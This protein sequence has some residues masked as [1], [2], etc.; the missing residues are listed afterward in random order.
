MSSGGE[1]YVDASEG[2]DP[3]GAYE[4]SLDLSTRST[5]EIASIAEAAGSTPDTVAWILMAQDA[6]IEEILR[7]DG[8]VSVPSLVLR[9]DPD[10]PLAEYLDANDV[11]RGDDQSDEA[12]EEFRT[13]S[14]GRIVY[15]RTSICEDMARP[16]GV[17]DDELARV[18]HEFWRFIGD[19]PGGR[20]VWDPMIGRLMSEA[21]LEELLQ[22]EPDRL[23][24]LIPEPNVMARQLDLQS[25]GRA[26]LVVGS[27]NGDLVVVEL[28]VG[29]GRPEDLDQLE[30]YLA[31]AYE[32]FTDAGGMLRGLLLCDGTTAAVRERVAQSPHLDYGLIRRDL[33]PERPLWFMRAS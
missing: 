22:R 4:P 31:P 23:S 29:H 30:R 20:E 12:M 17:G 1:R 15:T 21:A 25:A 27:G 32:L 3:L 28:K 18:I 11:L 5:V 9:L 2:R 19:E 24:S 33:V 16:P 6:L 10:D 14:D 7:C 8:I 13:L 26:D